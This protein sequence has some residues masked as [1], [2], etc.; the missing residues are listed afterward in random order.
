MYIHIYA[1]DGIF[2]YLAVINKLRMQLY[3]HVL[4]TK[5]PRF[6]TIHNNLKISDHLTAY[7]AFS[8]LSLSVAL[9]LWHFIIT[10]I[11]SK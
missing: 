7:V 3:G 5:A 6:C 4:L 11:S 8:V 1:Q 10:K 2:R 9:S